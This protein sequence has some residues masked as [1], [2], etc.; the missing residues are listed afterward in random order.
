MAL[1][2][3][4]R[5]QRR[6]LA[7][8]L[9]GGLGVGGGPALVQAQGNGDSASVRKSSAGIEEIVVTARKREESIQS[10]PVS[11]TAFTG[12]ALEKQSIGDLADIGEATPNLLFSQN[13]SK[14]NPRIY[15]RG[16]GSDDSLL[17][18]DPGVG[19]YVDGVY[20]ARTVALNLDL[21][22]VERVE[23]LRGPQGTL[24][25]RNTIGGAINIT[26]TKPSG[27]WGSHVK[28][29]VGT[30]GLLE[31]AGSLDFPI[32]PEV[33]S[34]R[35]SLGSTYEKGWFN[36]NF[37]GGS[38]WSNDRGLSA[39]GSFMLTPNDSSSYQLV[40]DRTT[41]RSHPSG[42]NSGS[43]CETGGSA[44]LCTGFA[45]NAG[46][47]GGIVK[48]LVEENHFRS[49]LGAG[50]GSVFLGKGAVADRGENAID[51]FGSSLISTFDLNDDI[52]FKATTAYR[53]LE[54]RESLDVDGLSI[55]I[56]DA[57]AHSLNSQ[58]SQEFQLN[59]NFMDGRASL[60]SGVFLFYEDALVESQTDTLADTAFQAALI[61]AG[62]AF[63]AGVSN[64]AA[65]LSSVSRTDQTTVSYAG[66]SHLEFD[67]TD[68]VQLEAGLRYTYDHK[69]FKVRTT[70]RTG[71]TTTN[72]RDTEHWDD[73]S[74]MIGVN[75]QMTDDVMLYA[76]WSSGF[77]G[78]Q[79]NGRANDL[80]ALTTS[81]V[82]PETVEVSEVGV[83]SSWLDNRLIVNLAAFRNNFEDQ[84]LTTFTTDGTRFVSVVQNAGKSR[85]LGAELDVTA[86]PTNE[87][88]LFGSLGAL[89]AKYLTFREPTLTGAMVTAITD[90]SNRDFK[91]TPELTF[92]VGSEYTF[93]MQI[94]AGW[95]TAR[96][97]YS[98]TS[99]VYFNTANTESIR[100]DK[101]GLLNGRISWSNDDDT[102]G[103]AIWGRNLLDRR[104]DAFGLDLNGALGFTSTYPAPPLQA[105]VEVTLRY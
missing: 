53:R 6:A 70:L 37:G 91:N 77:R 42:V 55:S 23:V 86:R 81:T 95:L 49:S 72:R 60:V 7:V 101:V 33:L 99:Q 34:G 22:D 12:E 13:S 50:A 48:P 24:Y 104:Y 89:N 28:A 57:L 47:F 66:Y 38:D 16:V 26:T 5:M 51:S 54:T 32:L 100:Q 79:F 35:I 85:I 82:N 25:G 68:R 59:T 9:A 11:I 105:G 87:L 64:T 1:F 80:N 29:N 58:A 83:K 92:N 65:A 14:D 76:K 20:I 19:I 31:T 102:M 8:L 56:L 97:D 2:R 3:E 63:S 62:G 45:A 88:T 96:V 17:T 74:P 30:D 98:H 93:P 21:L 61:G 43:L 44:S 69:L 84:Q 94:I 71:A 4:S 40:L 103:I 10:S 15:I 67:V 36:N 90:V 27:D 39:R 46:L 73:W 75:F 78:G 52:Q 18:I 41:K